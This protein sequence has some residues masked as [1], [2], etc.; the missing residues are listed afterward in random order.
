MTGTPPSISVCQCVCLY[1]ILEPPISGARPCPVQN[2]FAARPRPRPD[3]VLLGCRNRSVILYSS[4]CKTAR[5]TAE[6]Y[7]PHIWNL[8][9]AW[10]DNI[11][12]LCLQDMASLD[13]GFGPWIS[14]TLLQ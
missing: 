12:V 9:K 8:D 5:K 7:M 11:N 2:C 3:G 10:K 4:I 6:F 13:Q 1:R 14:A